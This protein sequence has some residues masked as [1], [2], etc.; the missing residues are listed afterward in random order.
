MNNSLSELLEEL[1]RQLGEL[2]RQ[3]DGA[4]ASVY[5]VFDAVLDSLNQGQMTEQAYRN[6]LGVAVE[7]SNQFQLDFDSAK[8]VREALPPPSALARYIGSRTR[9]ELAPELA[10]AEAIRRASE[11]GQKRLQSATR[12]YSSSEHAS[13]LERYE[14]VRSKNGGVVSADE[15]QAILDAVNEGKQ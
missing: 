14:A 1:N 4:I 5:R 6:C 3:R 12:L 13:I 7:Q 10:G 9:E 11:E 2:T 15:I 8:Y